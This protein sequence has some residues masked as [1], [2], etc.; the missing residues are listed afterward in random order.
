VPGR[1]LRIA[2]ARHDQPWCYT[3]ERG[4]QAACTT[5]PAPGS[6]SAP[7][8]V[9][10]RP[11]Q[12]VHQRPLETMPRSAR[13][14]RP[15]S[16]SPRQSRYSK[17]PSSTTKTVASPAAPV[18]RC[19]YGYE[20]TQ[21]VAGHAFAPG[22]ERLRTEAAPESRVNP[23][24]LRGARR[25]WARFGVG[26]PRGTPADIVVICGCS[27]SGWSAIRSGSK[28]G[29][30]QACLRGAGPPHK[31]TTRGRVGPSFLLALHRAAALLPFGAAADGRADAARAGRY[32]TT[33]ER[34][35]CAA[36]LSGKRLQT[37]SIPNIGMPR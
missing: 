2:S 13:R 9:P 18:P 17:L 27:A 22:A 28:G 15:I 35:S 10:Q 34:S 21:N 23:A 5:R 33:T 24:Y 20:A 6:K 25:C 19:P 4:T 26:A 14:W 29:P 31:R 12:F 1:K 16:A 32:L 30:A 11:D 3:G 7:F 37:S 8:I 36:A